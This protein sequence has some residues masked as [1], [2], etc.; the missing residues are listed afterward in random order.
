MSIQ[1]EQ[2]NL[3]NWLVELAPHRTRV[4]TLRDA[5][6]V[7]EQQHP[8]HVYAARKAMIKSARKVIKDLSELQA[9]EKALLRTPHSTIMARTGKR[10]WMLQQLVQG[11][12]FRITR[13]LVHLHLLCQN[14]KEKAH[15]YKG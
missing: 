8:E 15:A 13:H 1:T 6:A 7:L 14:G 10:V 11:R 4:T 12:A 3:E 5:L 2:F 9:A